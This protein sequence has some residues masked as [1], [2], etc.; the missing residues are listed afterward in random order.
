MVVPL[1]IQVK[2]SSTSARTHLR[3]TSLSFSVTSVTSIP[4]NIYLPTRLLTNKSFKLKRFF[5]QTEQFHNKKIKKK[6]GGDIRIGSKSNQ[7]GYKQFVDLKI[8]DLRRRWGTLT[9]AAHFHVVI[10]IQTRLRI[11]K[12][13]ISTKTDCAMTKHTE[14]KKWVIN[15]N[16]MCQTWCRMMDCAVMAEAIVKV[17]NSHKK[18]KVKQLFRIFFVNHSKCWQVKKRKQQQQQNSFTPTTRLSNGRFDRDW[19]ICCDCGAFPSP[20]SCLYFGASAWTHHQQPKSL[21]RMT[22]PGLLLRHNKY[23][24]TIGNY[25]VVVYFSSFGCC[26]AGVKQRRG[27]SAFHLKKRRAWR[28]NRAIL[29]NRTK[30]H[31]I[32]L[33]TMG[34]R[35]TQEGRKEPGTIICRLLGVTNILPNVSLL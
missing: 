19:R 20:I 5:V 28:A 35:E 24:S 21:Q 33:K 8:H 22:I 12:Q 34:Y 3:I 25:W 17:F 13:T 14:R 9:S 2:W 6:G 30:T 1:C 27:R 32:P 18:Q 11:C 16:W 4:G 7:L 10:H 29:Q 26:T 31:L 15:L 23:I